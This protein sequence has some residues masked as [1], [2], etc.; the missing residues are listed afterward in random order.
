MA[1]NRKKTL[2][3]RLNYFR[4]WQM[5]GRRIGKCT[6]VIY[7]RHECLNCGTSY[8]GKYCPH[9]GQGAKEK[10]LTFADIFNNLLG[11]VL[12][13]EKGFLYT[14]LCLLLRPGHMIRDYIEG[15]RVRY[16]RPIQ[17]LFI[18]AT[19]SIAVNYF[20]DD[21]TSVKPI[22]ICN[23]QNVCDTLVPDSLSQSAIDF[24]L[25]MDG[26]DL[27][28]NGAGN[29]KL[30]QLYNGIFDWMADNLGLTTLLFL[31]FLVFPLFVSYR[32]TR[33]GVTLNLTE[34]FF[35]TV[36]M[37]DQWYLLYL[38]TYPLP[39]SV[40][41]LMLFPVVFVWDCRQLFRISWGSSIRRMLLFSALAFV[42]MLVLLTL[43]IILIYYKFAL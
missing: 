40:A 6:D 27:I 28:K 38:I 15:K 36:Y 12:N 20:F 11:L 19:V 7:E 24:E 31:P 18:L 3:R 29:E 30:E 8:N 9:C 32:R 13:M 35:A 16:T 1:R 14:V 41:V 22:S 37:C 42:E 17:L 4:I 25:S 21:G 23:P 39:E 43:L 5:T 34:Y 33:G 26:E 2:R 10:R